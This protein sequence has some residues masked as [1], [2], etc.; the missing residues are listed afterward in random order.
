MTKAS[1][2]NDRL[3]LTFGALADPTRR[4]IL[5]KLLKGE[6]SVSELAKPFRMT[7]PA[8]SKHIKVLE[9]AGLIE[10]SSH[11]Q[12]RPCKIQTAPLQ[13]ADAWIDTYKKLWQVR[14]DQFEEYLR[15]LQNRDQ[16][17]E[18]PLGEIKFGKNKKS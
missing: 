11:A 7:L 12:W 8:I 15:D 6:T 13:E 10:R 3:S 2:E 9:R 16:K 14:F 5:K 1:L 18:I 4:E 17:A